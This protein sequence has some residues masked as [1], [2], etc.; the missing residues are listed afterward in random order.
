M[1]AE[2][3]ELFDIVLP[4]CF[5]VLIW[6][7]T[8]YCLKRAT[9][10][11][12]INDDGVFYR[13][14]FTSYSYRWAAIKDWGISHSGSGRTGTTYYNFYFSDKRQEF[15]NE[16]KLRLKGKMIVMTLDSE[17][18]MGVRDKVIPFCRQ[19]TGKRN[20]LSGNIPPGGLRN[21]RKCFIIN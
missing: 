18:I 21:V 6:G 10:K 11:I 15:K 12:E 13:D 19:R 2:E 3:F 7:L 4:I 16:D 14:I 9:A 5:V 8:A 1:T 17:E 20:F